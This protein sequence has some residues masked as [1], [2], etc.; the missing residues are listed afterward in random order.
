MAGNRTPLLIGGIIIGIVIGGTGWWLGSPLFLNRTVDEGF[1][2]ASAAVVPDNM[3]RAEVEQIM[4]GMVKIE[5]SMDE[6][7]ESSQEAASA[8]AQPMAAD[9][10]EAVKSGSFRD[11]D[12]FHRGSGQATIYR[13]PNGAHVLRLE[14]FRVTNGPDLR[15]LLS[16]HPDPMSRSDVQDAEYTELAKLKGN[17]GNQNYELPPDVD[18]ATQGSVVIYCKPFHVVFSVA[19]LS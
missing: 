3:T 5:E 4:A 13:L 6:P 15:V 10:P 8:D 16:T 2:L 11:A 17:V 7:M 18:V 19:P 1:P 12:S 14:N 9:E